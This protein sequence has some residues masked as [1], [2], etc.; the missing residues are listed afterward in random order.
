MNWMLVSASTLRIAITGPLLMVES[1]P[2]VRVLARL[3][4]LR[5]ALRA[6]AGVVM[7]F[8]GAYLAADR[9]AIRAGS[10]S[11]VVAGLAATLFL[12]LRLGFAA[13]AL[14]PNDLGYR[15]KGIA[16]FLAGVAVNA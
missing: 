6:C 7:L 1:T 3:R 12:A 15:T 13:F 4:Q 9:Q 16:I 5:L 11:F 8:G 2:E 14:S 10:R